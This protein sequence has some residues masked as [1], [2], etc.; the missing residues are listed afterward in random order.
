MT[1]PANGMAE[2]TPLSAI[3]VLN[4]VLGFAARHEPMALLEIRIL[5]QRSQ[6][7]LADC[8]DGNR[9]R[10][11]AMVVAPADGASLLG[12]VAR[13]DRGAVLSFARVCAAEIKAGAQ[14]VVEKTPG[15]RLVLR[16]QTAGHE[17][18]AR[19]R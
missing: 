1:K 6:I 9:P 12:A 14:A 8:L 7:T 15:G 17:S 16:L 2:Q 19:N 5:E 4:R 10:S 18:L 13:E 11:D 3:E